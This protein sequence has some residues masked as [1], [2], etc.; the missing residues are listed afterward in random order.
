MTSWVDSTARKSI[1]E[2]G[3]QAQKSLI[4][5]FGKLGKATGPALG[6]FLKRIAKATIYGGSAAGGGVLL[7]RRLFTLYPDTFGWLE[8]ALRFLHLM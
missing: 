6:R 1:A 7:F 8:S 3:K 2:F 5:E 4:K